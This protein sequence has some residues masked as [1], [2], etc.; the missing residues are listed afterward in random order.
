MINLNFWNIFEKNKCFVLF[1]KTKNN[2]AKSVFLSTDNEKQP[3]I[4]VMLDNESEPFE[5]KVEDKRVAG[6]LLKFF[7]SKANNTTKAENQILYFTGLGENWFVS[8][9][10][11]LIKSLV[12]DDIRCVQKLT[13]EMSKTGGMSCSIQK[14]DV[15]KC[16]IR[17]LIGFETD[18]K[19]KDAKNKQKTLSSDKKRSAE[20]EERSDSSKSKLMEI[21]EILRNYGIDMNDYNQA[22]VEVLL[23]AI[24]KGMEQLV[25]NCKAPVSVE[26]KQEEKTSNEDWQKK[27]EE[28][29]I[30][31]SMLEEKIQELDQ[32]T[33]GKNRVEK[34]VE[35]KNAEIEQLKTK[36]TQ[37]ENSTFDIKGELLKSVE[38]LAEDLRQGE[39]LFDSECQSVADNFLV[40]QV[41]SLKKQF[42]EV[43]LEDVNQLREG[44]KRIIETSLK[45]EDN[46]LNK[47][48]CFYAYSRLP[49][50][51][52]PNGKDYHFS[53]FRMSSIYNKVVAV[54]SPFGFHQIIPQLFVETVE[55][56][57]YEVVTGEKVSKLS[58]MC[59]LLGQHREK[60][61]RGQQTQVIMDI[62]EVGY[63]K[64]GLIEKKTKVIIQ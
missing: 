28:K 23:Q 42:E 11:F 16:S 9:I 4:N 63:V 58:N 33:T 24:K 64:N 55:D 26:N 57:D 3:V 60:V 48:A 47:L 7:K 41:D 30:E 49:F 20:T 38:A 5:I 40:T 27:L 54:L 8:D 51:I 21:A 25:G 13:V 6:V 61:D 59:S 22:S 31:I 18:S 35:Q 53:S 10:H 43:K 50:M 1:V 36:I 17:K 45:E 39:Y 12:K 32:M 52:E 14:L 29:D 56:G 62:A 46:V 19:N 34:E 2:K 37:L 15:E 44:F